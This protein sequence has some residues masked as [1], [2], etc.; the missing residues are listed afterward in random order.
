M[1]TINS[2]DNIKIA[3]LVAFASA[4]IGA[5]SYVLLDSLMHLDMQPFYPITLVNPMQGCVSVPALY[6]F[7]LYSAMVGGV[8]YFIVKLK[9]RKSPD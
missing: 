9:K 7:C 6:K 4:F 3:W 1:R 8:A 5:F 2:L